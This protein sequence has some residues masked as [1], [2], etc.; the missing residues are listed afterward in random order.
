VGSIPITRSTNQPEAIRYE[1]RAGNPREYLD[2]RHAQAGPAPAVDQGMHLS[3]N[4]SKSAL[5]RLFG[6]WMP[7]ETDASR[8]DVAERLGQWLGV[9]ELIALQAELES[10][11][12]VETAPDDGTR[13]PPAA[14][15]QQELQRVCVSLQQSIAEP[16][17]QDPQGGY[18]R[19]RQR[20]N[21]A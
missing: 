15:L 10:I 3:G 11:A 7:Q 21:A 5:L 16:V 19:Y 6:S 2:R 17:A 20:Q 9:A 18:A 4:F 1:R 14:A 8:Q 12:G 13:V